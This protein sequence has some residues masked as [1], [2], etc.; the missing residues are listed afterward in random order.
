[1]SHQCI[2]CYISSPAVL[3]SKL[4]MSESRVRQTKNGEHMHSGL[5]YCPAATSQRNAH[6]RLVDMQDASPQLAG[7][8][9]GTRIVP[10]K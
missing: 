4:S 8:A 2:R 3:T 10:V 5:V 6:H 1:M 9:A 7:L